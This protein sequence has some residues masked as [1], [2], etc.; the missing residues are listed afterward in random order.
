[1]AKNFPKLINNNKPRQKKLRNPY[2]EFE[3]LKTNKKPQTRL[4]QSKQIYTQAYHR[5]APETKRI[6]LCV[7]RGKRNIK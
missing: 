2:S 3:R 7:A 4:N 6:N 1:M 5:Q